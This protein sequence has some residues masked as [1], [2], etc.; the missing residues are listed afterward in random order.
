[1][2]DYLVPNDLPSLKPY[3][4]KKYGRLLDEDISKIEDLA[5]RLAKKRG[6]SLADTGTG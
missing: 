4:K 5:A 1:L 6:F 2:A 3:L